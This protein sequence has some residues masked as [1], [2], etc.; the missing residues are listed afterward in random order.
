[1]FSHLIASTFLIY[2]SGQA[3]QVVTT[4]DLQDGQIMSNT[5]ATTSVWDKE[6]RAFRSI[7]AFWQAYALRSGGKYWGRS[8]EYPPYDDVN[9]HD[10]LLIEVDS[11]VCLMEFFHSRWRRANAVRRWDERYDEYSGCPNVFD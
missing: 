3:G 10:T 7:E 5:H 11:G 8:N 1:M 9:E 2:I 4:N 6:A